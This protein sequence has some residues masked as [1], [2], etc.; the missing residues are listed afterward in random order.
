MPHYAVN[1]ADGSRIAYSSTGAGEPL[2]LVH[3]SGLSQ[4]IW[5]GFGYTKAFADSYRVLTVD[6]RGH[7]RSAKPHR[8]QD[9]A[10]DLVVA[11][12]EAVLDAAGA[13]SCHYFG[14]SFGA[15][16]GFALAAAAPARLRSFVSAGGTYGIAPGSIA[17]VFFPGWE[18]ALRDGGMEGFVA[19]WEGHLGARLDPA[20]RTAF[21]VNDAGALA[22]Y[23]RRTE[24]EPGLP[25]SALPGIEVPTLLLA[26]SDDGP[27][28]A[29]STRAAEL[30]PAAELVVLAGRNHATTLAPAAAV[31]DAV[32]PFLLRSRSVRDT[33]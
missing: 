30:M 29:D 14:Y 9:Y 7:G 15:R 4:A 10:M 11:D 1:P 28:L 31:L 5:R 33:R 27:R 17:A 32:V 19:G 24:S 25:E 3:G 26:G 18:A 8:P 6:L 13:G 16:A 20:T 23:F 21:L 2:L 12:L 22:A